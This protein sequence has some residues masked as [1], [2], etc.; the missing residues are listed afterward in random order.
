MDRLSVKIVYEYEVRFFHP[1]NYEEVEEELH[2]IVHPEFYSFP[3]YR[4]K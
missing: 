1:D 4:G 3:R 2:K